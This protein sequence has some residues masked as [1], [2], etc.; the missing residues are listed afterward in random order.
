MS[1]LSISPRK[2]TPQPKKIIIF[3][4][5][6]VS[7]E[8][9]LPRSDSKSTGPCSCF[10]ICSVITLVLLFGCVYVLV[11]CVF[12]ISSSTYLPPTVFLALPILVSLVL[13][14]IFIVCLIV[15]GKSFCKF[16]VGHLLS[17]GNICLSLFYL[18]EWLKLFGVLPL[19]W[20]ILCIPLYVSGGFFLVAF[21]W[22]LVLYL[23]SSSKKGDCTCE[24]IG[25]II[26]GADSGKASNI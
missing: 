26:F 6:Y 19:E 12:A 21:I 5:K 9:L 20:P 22:F 18:G 1:R 14:V 11:P 23:Q 25:A 10:N 24:D 7:L 2:R 17:F 13:S 3:K 4:S 15:H 8:S 16:R